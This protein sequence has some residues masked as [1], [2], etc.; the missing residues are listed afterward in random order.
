[1]IK[2]GEYQT[3][4]DFWEKK[5]K[6]IN[7]RKPTEMEELSF[8]IGYDNG[9]RTGFNMGVKYKQFEQE[10]NNSEIL[11]LCEIDKIKSDE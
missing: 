9:F 11:K 10:I 1:M 6:Q 8:R 7:K 3:K 4:R 5:F 2:M